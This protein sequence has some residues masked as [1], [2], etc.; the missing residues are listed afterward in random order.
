MNEHDFK[1]ITKKIQEQPYTAC[2]RIVLYLVWLLVV[3][4]ICLTIAFV[5]YINVEH[6]NE[7]TRINAGLNKYELRKVKR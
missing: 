6:E 3:W 5:N 7:V 4:G 1:S 2:Q